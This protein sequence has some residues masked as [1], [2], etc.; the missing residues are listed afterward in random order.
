METK[1]QRKYTEQEVVKVYRSA[2]EQGK[3]QGI[4]DLI[5]AITNVASGA[6]MLKSLIDETNEDEPHP[7]SNDE[8]YLYELNFIEEILK[9]DE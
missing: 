4:K 8:P 3:R 5:N 9:D 7:V 6:V 2:I 1:Q